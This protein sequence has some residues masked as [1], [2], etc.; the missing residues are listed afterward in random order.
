MHKTQAGADGLLVAARVVGLRGVLLGGLSLQL[1]QALGGDHGGLS[2]LPAC[3]RRAGLTQVAGAIVCSRA[4]AALVAFSASF[5]T[6]KAAR[7]ASRAS[8]AS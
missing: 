1:L 6:T 4:A 2:R 3:R 5:E 8:F 7:T